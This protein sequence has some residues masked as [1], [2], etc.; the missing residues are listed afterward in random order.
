[1]KNIFLFFFFLI[2]LNIFS[3]NPEKGRLITGPVLGTVTQTTARLWI[4]FRGAGEDMISLIDT[5]DKSIYHPTHFEKISD[6]KGNFAANMNFTD[7]QP[8]H[9]YKV[10]YALEPAAIRP[11][12]I[13]QTQKTEPVADFKFLMG[14]CA[15][16]TPGFARLV[17]PGRAV[18]IFYYMKRKQSDFMVWLGDNVYYMFKDY[19]NYDN[20]FSRQLKIRNGFPL[21]ADFLNGQPNYAIWDDHDYGW[22]DADSTFP[23]KNDALKVFKGFWPNQFEHGDTTQ[24]IYYSYRYYDAEFFMTDNRWFLQPEGDTAGSF[25]GREQ[26]EWLKKKLKSSDATFKFI[27]IGS[28]VLSD[29]WYDDSYAKFPVERNK[30]LDFIAENNIPGVVFLTGDKHFTELS[31]R[32]WKGYPFYDFTSS[33]LTSPIT[34]TKNLSG[35]FNTYSIASTVLY[36]RN[37]GQLSITGEAGNRVCKMEVFGVGGQKKWEYVINAND[38]KRKAN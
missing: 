5:V 3:Q 24:G 9:F 15:Y 1:M 14:S 6:H 26:S 20:M 27:S 13:F 29:A 21:L 32:D 23:Q 10:Q 19:K 4:A 17:F 36:K 12:C 34:P 16:M 35:Y 30:L 22:N 11:K 18:Q 33:P 7:L 38:L 31:K 37:F 25:L 2:S 28:Q 8:G